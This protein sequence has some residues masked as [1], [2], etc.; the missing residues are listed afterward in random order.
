MTDTVK[1]CRCFL[2]SLPAEGDFGATQRIEFCP[3]H[4]AAGRM[5]VALSDMKRMVKEEDLYDEEFADRVYTLLE[6]I[7]PVLVK[8]AATESNL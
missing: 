6:S 7:D 1:K 5:Y 2:V 4:E 8:I 3:L